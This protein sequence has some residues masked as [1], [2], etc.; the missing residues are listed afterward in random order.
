MLFRSLHGA[1]PD[2]LILCYEMGREVIFD[3]E[4]YRLPS[5][6]KTRDFYETAAAVMHPCR[7]I[8]VSINGSKYSDAL[9]AAE[10]EKVRAELGLPACDP[11]RHGPDELVDAVLDLK[12]TL[13]K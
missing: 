6:E 10:R 11:I 3:M 12:R 9:V 13:G 4:Q 5:L 7:V 8:G 1:I 2:G